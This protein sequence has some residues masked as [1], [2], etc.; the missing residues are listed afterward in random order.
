MNL[1]L[2]TLM[3]LL[4]LLVPVRAQ[5][6]AAVAP[7]H[8]A[9]L[10]KA[11]IVITDLDLKP[12]T[13]T[14]QNVSARDWWQAE[15]PSPSEQ[16][17]IQRL[18]K[19]YRALLSERARRQAALASEREKQRGLE[20][21]VIHRGSRSDALRQGRERI[22]ELQLQ[23][24]NID[25]RINDLHTEARKLGIPPVILRQARHAWEREKR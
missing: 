21:A 8:E 14:K 1:S 24:R 6:V 13:R 20:R 15:P 4:V 2:A 22:R 9:R 5:S 12:L 3:C 18:Q 7:S 11:R 10:K 17:T 19:E 16:K 23:L 25:R